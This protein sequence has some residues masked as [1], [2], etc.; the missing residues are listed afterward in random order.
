M[1]FASLTNSMQDEE[2]NIAG[3]SAS[4]SLENYSLQKKYKYDFQNRKDTYKKTRQ[5]YS[6]Q[7]EEQNIAGEQASSSQR[8]IVYKIN[9]KYDLQNQKETYQKTTEKYAYNMLMKS[10]LMQGNSLQQKENLI[11]C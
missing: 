6:Y 1:R 4:S 9:K 2:Q 8:T 10:K 5:K 7:D 3:E 11:Q